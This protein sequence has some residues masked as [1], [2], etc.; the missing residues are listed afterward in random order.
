MQHKN[1]NSAVAGETY[2]TPV[3]GLRHKYND[4]HDDRGRFASGAGGGDEKEPHTGPNPPPSGGRS[5]NQRTNLNAERGEAYTKS[6]EADVADQKAGIS[7][8]KSD[9]RAA[10]H[11]HDLAADAHL[12]VAAKAKE[13]GSV[14]GMGQ[15]IAKTHRAQASS[16]REAADAARKAA[17][18][19]IHPR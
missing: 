10:G 19:E 8:K 13:S 2:I 1:Q 5:M 3:L 18:K 17:G 9:Y 4:S 6:G 16:H 12:A 15:S 7:G 14:D 11:A